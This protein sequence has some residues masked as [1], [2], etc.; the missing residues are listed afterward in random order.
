M[1]CKVPMNKL[2]VIFLFI[3]LINIL[4]GG[5]TVIDTISPKYNLRTP[6]FCA[7]EITNL[8]A[9]YLLEKSSNQLFYINQKGDIVNNAGGFGWDAH[10]L[11]SPSD[12]ASNSGL[13]IYVADNSN[14][15]I[16]RFDKSVNYITYF[17]NDNSLLSLQYPYKLEISKE[18]AIFILPEDSFEIL[19]LLPNSDR[20]LSI[21]TTVKKD[22]ELID[23]IDIE[24]TQNN[25]LYVLETSGKVLSFDNYGT[26]LKI[27]SLKT[28][29]YHPQKLMVHNQTLY[30]LSKNNSLYQL[31]AKGW[32]NI[33]QSQGSNLQDC[34]ILNN[35]LYLLTQKGK[36]ITCELSKK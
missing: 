30:I 7:M 24:L 29:K 5:V 2:K 20:F 21:G 19:K 31:S 11:N 32:K 4:V 14:H 28:E 15:R 18:G 6:N 13:N 22:Y 17:P 10:N 12:I 3:I 26:P 35:H 27:H 1:T 34:Q 33:Y 8:N 23:P 36:I 9:I 16:V 25:I